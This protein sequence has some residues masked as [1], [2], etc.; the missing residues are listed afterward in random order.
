MNVIIEPFV[1]CKVH[2]VNKDG[3][4]DKGPKQGMNG[5]TFVSTKNNAEI[6]IWNLGVVEPVTLTFVKGADP[7]VGG[8]FIMYRDDQ[9]VSKQ[10]ESD[11]PTR[12]TA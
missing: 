6:S 7:I 2:N 4:I 1:K 8:N 10:G 5:K 11:K 9:I 3:W 12:G